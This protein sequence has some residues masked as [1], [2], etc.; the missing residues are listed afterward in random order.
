MQLGQKRLFHGTPLSR[1]SSYR[2]LVFPAEPFLCKSP[3][4]SSLTSS[5]LRDLTWVS[6]L[7][8][9][10]FYIIFLTVNAFIVQ[11][12]HI[13]DMLWFTWQG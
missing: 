13:P 6:F 2:G 5:T 1:G 7:S 4:V 3:V 12:S 11:L 9:L 10:G 8:F